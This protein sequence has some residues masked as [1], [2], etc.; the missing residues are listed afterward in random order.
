MINTNRVVPMEKTDLLS[1]IYLVYAIIADNATLDGV[2]SASGAGGD[3]TS[4]TNN[5]VYFADEPLRSCNF[6]SGVT[7]GTVYFIPAYDYQGFTTNGSK[8]TMAGAEVDPDG[9][10]YYKAVLSSGTVTISKI[11]A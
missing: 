9:V 3:F 8:P 7:A 5:K 10:T 2:I 11:G 1:M 6:A 4:G